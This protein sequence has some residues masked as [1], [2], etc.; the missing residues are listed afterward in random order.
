MIHNIVEENVNWALAHGIRHL[1]AVGKPQP[2]RNGP[3]LVAPLPV[4]TTYT[5]PTQRVLFSPIR[6]A[7]PFFHLMEA[8]WMLNG[9]NDVAWPA[10]FAKNIE[11]YSDDA[12]T[13]H[14][15]YGHRWRKHFEF[16]Q[17]GYIVDQLKKNPD[18]RR[19]VLSMWDAA[20][21][22]EV[23]ENGGKDVPCNT[24]AYFSVYSGRLNMLV[25]CRSN[26]IIWGCYGANAVH[27]SVLLE[28][29]AARLGLKVGLYQ[30]LSYNYHAYIEKYP[31]ELLRKIATDSH[32]YNEYSRPLALV[33][34][35]E[36]SLDPKVWDA[37]L[38]RFM[39][40]PDGPPYADDCLFI[41]KVARPMYR[42]WLQRKLKQGSGM[43]WAEKIAAGD[44]RIA[45]MDWIKRKE[46]RNVGQEA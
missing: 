30:Q 28:Y 15:A 12:K 10:F 16:D 31:E 8:L 9:D 21:D 44:W 26:D 1:L 14:G 46:G 18:G 4:C 19:V 23:A 25:C 42:A 11:S 13:L 27:F 39:E 29:L 36:Q 43:E 32:G 2:S 33:P 40:N 41:A 34:L 3:V 24:H 22:I 17:L 6:D 20:I 38:S 45:C 35:M 5:K 37:Q 7:N